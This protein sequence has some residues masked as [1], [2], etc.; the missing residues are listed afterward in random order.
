MQ[1]AIRPC[2]NSRRLV[3]AANQGGI[4]VRNSNV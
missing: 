2:V 4:D 1:N 3:E